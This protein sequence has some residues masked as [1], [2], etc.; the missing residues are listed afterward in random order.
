MAR[1]PY[2]Q[3]T[4]IGGA[5]L[6]T[7]GNNI[8]NYDTTFTLNNV[9]SSWATLGSGGG[10]YLVIDFGNIYEEKVYVPSGT[11]NYSS[12]TI[13]LSSISRG[14]DGT[15]A[16]Q[17]TLGATVAPT[18]TAVDLQEANNL[19]AQ[20][21]GQ[22]T[23][24]T[25]GQALALN[26]TGIG[27]ANFVFQDILPLDDMSVYFTGGTSTFTA[28]Y[29]GVPI[30]FTNPLSLQ[31]YLSGIPQAWNQPEWVWLSYVPQEGFQVDNN[32]N[33][34]FQSVPTTTSAQTPISLAFQGTQN[35]A[36]PV[37]NS[38]T[39]YPFQATDVMLGY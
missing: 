34:F 10:F 22:V 19:V 29:Q 1:V 32:G 30:K 16:Q 12:G 9:G 14:V 7:L 39:I 2:T 38:Q 31:M 18:L 27:F 3:N 11:Y 24:A 23:T 25:S 15:T 37:N 35:P 20:T 26:G 21:L 33:I 6:A 17:H 4:Y 8:L 28:T 36:P 13:T 5:T